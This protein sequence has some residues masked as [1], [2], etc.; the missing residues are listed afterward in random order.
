MKTTLLAYSFAA[1]CGAGILHLIG[2]Q[3]KW[4]AVG[5]GV[6]MLLFGLFSKV[7]MKSHEAKI[8]AKEMI[9]EVN[10]MVINKEKANNLN[11]KEG[12]KNGI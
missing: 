11:K 9:D 2:T 7:K 5:F 12:N 10:K 3:L 4:L 6:V 8:K 1:F